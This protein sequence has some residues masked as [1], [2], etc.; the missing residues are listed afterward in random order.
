MINDETD[1]VIRAKKKTALLELN[2]KLLDLKKTRSSRKESMQLTLQNVS[3]LYPRLTHQ[4]SGCSSQGAKVQ[5]HRKS[6]SFD[7]H[8][9][10]DGPGAADPHGPAI[11]YGVE[12]EEIE[13]INDAYNDLVED[14]GLS[15]LTENELEEVMPSC[16]PLLLVEYIIFKIENLWSK[17]SGKQASIE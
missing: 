4:Q 5:A 17:P 6:V 16:G 9:Y 8:R 15:K 12:S 13:E 3:S 7:Q 10:L 1:E 14:L 2:T 11:I